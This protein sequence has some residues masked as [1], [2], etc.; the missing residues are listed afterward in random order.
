MTS[1]DTAELQRLAAARRKGRFW[2][3]VVHF[4]GL[5][6]LMAPAVLWL[7][8]N[9]Y[10]PMIGVIIAFKDVN[11][12]VGI[13]RSPWA[14]FRNFHYLFSTEAA[15]IITRNTLFYNFTFI[16]LDV[17][18]PV[19]LALLLNELRGRVLPR[20]YHTIMLFPYFI[21]MVV[22]SYLVF[23]MLSHEHGLLNVAVLPSLGREPVN[24]YNETKYWPVILPTIHVWKTAGY[25]TIVYLASLAGI[26]PSYY[27]AAAID[28]AGKWKQARFISL[29]F[30]QPVIIILSILAVGRIFHSDFGL[31]Y[32]VPLNSGAIYSVTNVI[33]TYVYRGLTQ[34]NDLGMASA[35]G[36]YQAVV[37]FV[38]VLTANTV[39]RRLEPDQALF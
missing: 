5:L 37:G 19:T 33:D 7:I 26:D 22:V 11:Y 20:L 9:R 6:L 1:I 36:F 8:V 34:T 30:L 10:L 35:A 16:V 28:G 2:R 3:N 17:L 21:S 25:T 32:Q 39:V 14:G 18:I 27:D 13:L 24:W 12:S 23:S 38:L 31:F 15:Y 4:R 29:P